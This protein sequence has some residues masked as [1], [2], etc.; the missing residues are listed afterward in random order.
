M[1]GSLLKGLAVGGLGLVS[2]TAGG[3]LAAFRTPGRTARSAVQHL[4]AGT[5]FAGLVV[6]VLDQLLHDRAYF[7]WII[8]GMAVGLAAMLTIRVVMRRREQ[9]GGGAT[10]LDITIIAD[11]VTDGVLMG[12][13]MATGRPTAVLFAVALAPE[14]FFLGVTAAEDFGRE[15]QS[16]GRPVAITF[17][18]GVAILVGALGGAL[19]SAAPHSVSAAVLAFGAI[20][21]SYLVMEELL[22]EAHQQKVSPLMAALFFAGFVPFFLGGILLTG[23]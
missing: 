11:V 5:V 17:G 21:I 8:V 7:W 22:R 23:A 4:A 2:I 14:L 10:S 6:E 19:L 9:G 18:I 1:L 15:G 3:T 12:L 13:A 20:A 16:R